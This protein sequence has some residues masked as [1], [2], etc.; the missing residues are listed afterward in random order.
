MRSALA[1]ISSRS[2]VIPI[3]QSIASATTN[4]KN[5]HAMPNIICHLGVAWIFRFHR[6]RY[7]RLRITNATPMAVNI[8]RLIAGTV[9][10]IRFIACQSS[11]ET[12]QIIGYLSPATYAAIIVLIPT[13]INL[14]FL[15]LRTL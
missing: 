3:S 15:R 14:K 6:G 4:G 7:R 8:A 12:V 13:E 1:D 10:W 9:C 5:I 2:L 11:S